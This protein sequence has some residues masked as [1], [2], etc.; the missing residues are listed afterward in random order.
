MLM[1]AG[2]AGNLPMDWSEVDRLAALPGF[3]FS[4]DRRLQGRGG[5]K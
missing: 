4:R 1:G 2:L 5:Q 3:K